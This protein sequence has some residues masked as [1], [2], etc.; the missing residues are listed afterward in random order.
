[1]TISETLEASLQL[2]RI[3]LHSSGI[4]SEEATRLVRAFRRTY[5]GD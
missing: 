4:S 3:V 2:S 1:M 5:H